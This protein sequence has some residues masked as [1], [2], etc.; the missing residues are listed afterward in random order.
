MATVSVISPV[1]QEPAF[2]VRCITNEEFD[3]AVDRAEKAFSGW[4]KVPVSERVK[5]IQKFC[6]IFDTKQEEV[7]ESLVQQMGRPRRYGGGEIK[8]VRERSS[9]MC[10]VAEES[11][12]D[13]VVEEQSNVKR[14]IKKEPLGPIFIIASWNYPYLTAVNNVIPALLAGN[15]VLL[16][17]SLQTPK[18]A[19]LFVKVLH[20]AGVPEDIVQSVVLTDSGSEY[21]TNHPGIKFVSF[22]GSVAVGKKIRK[23]LGTTKPLIGSGMELGGKDPAYVLSDSDIAYAAENIVDGAFFNSGQCCCS[24]ERCYVDAKVYD[25]FVEKAVAITKGYVLGNPND[26]ET[27]IGPMANIQ[28]ANNVRAQLKDAESKGAKLLIATEKYFSQDKTGSTYIGPQIVVNV[29]HDM[30]IMKEE[31]FGPVLAI[32]P[33]SSEEEAIRLMNDSDY[34]LTA[35]IWTTDA[36]KAIRIGDQIETGTWFMNRCDYIDPA[37][38]WVGAKD[39]GSGFSMSKHGFNA[40]VRQKSYH[41]KLKQQ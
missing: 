7:A 34:G 1:N 12:K 16:K 27:T 25:K 14:Y 32:M 28:F 31:T 41:L 23:S 4:R 40:F 6:D 15:P 13:E 11:L 22:T 30:V 20:E 26:M 39:S 5:I 24:I 36:E 38:P 35:S 2:S 18:C 9:Y 3:Q 33:V 29:N 10:S 21:A 17:Q 8:G 37:L 19:E